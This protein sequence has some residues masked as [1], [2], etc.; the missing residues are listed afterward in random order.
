MQEQLLY[1]M[2]DKENEE[3]DEYGRPNKKVRLKLD[4]IYE[5][6]AVGVRISN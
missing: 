4:E 6:I 1:K 5:P 2:K 3:Y